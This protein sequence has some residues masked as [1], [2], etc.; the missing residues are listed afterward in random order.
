MITECEGL[1]I[2]RTKILK[3]R[4]MIA[5]LTDRFGKISAGTAVS[6]RG[7]SKSALALRPFTVGRY[8]LKRDRGF[9]NIT[10][11]ETI[12]SYFELAEDYDKFLNAS[13]AVELT[14]KALPE[15][16]PAADVYAFLL[17]FLDMTLRRSRDIP[18]LTSAYFVKLLEA[19]GVFPEADNFHGNEL[20]LTLD[21]DIVEV[22]MFLRGNPI[23]RVEKLALSSEI[24]AKLLGFLI[25]YAEAHLDIGRLKS[26]FVSEET[27]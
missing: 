6:E 4:S 2:R 13:I 26:S 9:T 15:D 14:Y 21:S 27:P 20:L 12:K 19:F 10:G 8:Q 16:A 25:Q 11:G 17:E 3:G 24:S 23:G 7:K 5:L 22:L 18:T 1:V